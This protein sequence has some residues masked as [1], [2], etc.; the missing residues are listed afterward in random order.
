VVFPSRAPSSHPLGVGPPAALLGLFWDV[1]GPDGQL[2]RQLPTDP[3]PIRD[4][5]EVGGPA[6]GDRLPGVI[7]H[8]TNSEIPLWL[9][10]VSAAGGN[11][12]RPRQLSGFPARP[13]RGRQRES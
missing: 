3:G 8:A 13:Q 7:V 4:C 6:G 10:G 5:P 12:L 9:S 1:G 2:L 11:K